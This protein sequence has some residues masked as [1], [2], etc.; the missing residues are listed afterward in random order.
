MR[1]FAHVW[2]TRAISPGLRCARYS[3][4]VPYRRPSREISRCRELKNMAATDSKTS[5]S[6]VMAASKSR[7]HF[8][9]ALDLE[10][11]AY[12]RSLNPFADPVQWT[13]IAA[14]MQDIAG[15]PFNARNVRSRTELLLSYYAA[16]DMVNLRKSGSEEQYSTREALLQELLDLSREHGVQIR[17]RRIGNAAPV[18][19]DRC[20][21]APEAERKSAAA[22]R[23]AAAAMN[24]ATQPSSGSYIDCGKDGETAAELFNKMLQNEEE[25]NE[26]GAELD[27]QLEEVD[28]QHGDGSGSFMESRSQATPSPS[29]SQALLSATKAASQVDS[30]HV[31]TS[32]AAV[33][34]EP[35]RG[36][37]RQEQVADFEFLEK[38]MHH[39][40]LM[41]E[42][43]CAM[44]ARRLAL[45]ERRLAW[46]EERTRLS[47]S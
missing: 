44:E 35:V 1:A 2:D 25:Y 29:D 16:K 34:T 46:E 21:L 22:K 14:K 7:V 40:L 43:E 23:D 33:R 38:R 5:G 11:L 45:E 39:D 42:K 18:P 41:K 27:S 37:K 36:K 28:S 10:L 15:R 6:V 9:I 3:R 17:R 26:A 47:C 24:V 30:S 32:Q 8:G 20:T 4:Y 13:V 19:R 31:S 12:V